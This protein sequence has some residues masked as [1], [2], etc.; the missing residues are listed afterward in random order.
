M[1]RK[2]QRKSENNI[3][4]VHFCVNKNFR[5]WRK[6]PMALCSYCKG[7]NGSIDFTFSDITAY[8]KAINNKR[9][10]LD[11]GWRN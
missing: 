1:K 5:R 4:R 6:Y 9:D 11:D 10:V 8:R 3:I 7:K 2:I